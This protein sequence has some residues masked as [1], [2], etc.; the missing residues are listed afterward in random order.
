MFDVFTDP[1]GVWMFYQGFQYG[2]ITGIVF[3][4]WLIWCQLP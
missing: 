1:D 2:A 3:A 4:L